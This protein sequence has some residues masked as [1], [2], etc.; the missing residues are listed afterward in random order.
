MHLAARIS[1]QL[2]AGAFGSYSTRLRSIYILLGPH[3]GVR[4]NI[5]NKFHSSG[6]IQKRSFHHINKLDYHESSKMAPQ[7]HIK[8]YTDSTPNGIKITTALEE[9]GLPYE[10]EHLDIST[11][12]QKEPWYLEINP[13]GR[14]PAIVDTFDDGES[15]RVFEGGSILQYLTDRYDPEH[16]LSFPKGSREYYEC[17]NWLF[18]QHGGRS[19]GTFVFPSPSCVIAASDQSTNCCRYLGIG[20]MQGQASH[21][22][23]YAPTKIQYGIDRYVT[24]TKRLYNVLDVQLSKS[25]SGF[26]VGDHISIADIAALSWVIFGPYVDVPLDFFPNVQKWEAMLSARPAITRGFHIPKVLG[27]KSD[28]PEGAAKYQ[29]RHADWVFKGMQADQQAFGQK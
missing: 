27:I 2:F 22:L 10:L 28:D 21:F 20:P 9:L 12:R 29:Q 19:I 24:E 1:K 11:L 13:N 17:N 5:S 16:K 4:D 8:L 15:I 3:P 18:F 7:P 25:K 6:Q 14:I 23:R 26:L